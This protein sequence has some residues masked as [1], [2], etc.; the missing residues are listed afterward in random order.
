MRIH[1][2]DQLVLDHV[3]AREAAIVGRAIDWSGVNSGSRNAEGLARMLERLETE[4]RRL[5]AEV[6]RIATQDSA[7]VG[8]DGAVRTEAHADALKITARPDAPIQVVLTGHYDTVFPADSGFQTVSTRPDG[9][10]NGPGLADMKG[11]ISVMLAALEAFET[12]PDRER[13][14]WTVLLSPDE[15]IGSPA[16]APLL[17]AL[18]ARGH[19]GMTYEPALADG[20]LAGARKGSGNYHLIVSGRAAHAGRAF[21]EGAN[22][23][24]GAAILAARLH[25]L[26]GLRDGVTVNVAKISGGGALNVVADNAVVRFNVRVPDRAASDWIEAAVR[27]IAAHAPFP[28]LTLDLHGG[29]TRAPKPMDASQTALFEAVRDTGAL[30]GQTVAWKPSGGVCEGN[31]L[32]AAGLPNVD[33]LGVLGGD[34]H[35]DQEFAW[36]ASFVERARLSALILCKIA[37]GEIDALKLKSLRLETM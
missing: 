1:P 29:M 19:I 22:A 15:E 17:A 35:S 30:L 18:G 5:P 36:P 12:H 27:E 6:R 23:V 34:I 11:G 31:N 13:V 2:S 25:A 14:G 26:N 16:S 4:A 24:A 20:T 21:H 7:S 9:A 10:L 3:A 32:H 33:T 37:S 28:G 8:D